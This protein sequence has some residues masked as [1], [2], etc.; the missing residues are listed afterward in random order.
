MTDGMCLSEL[1]L[2]FLINLCIYVLFFSPILDFFV[3]IYTQLEFRK[4]DERRTNHN[5]A[6]NLAQ[7]MERK[8]Y[9]C[10]LFIKFIP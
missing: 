6:I 5:T 4:M 1:R 9:S 3:N 7:I 8:N 10:F 2:G